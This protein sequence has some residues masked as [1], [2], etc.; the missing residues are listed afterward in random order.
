MT[1]EN[2][3][4]AD[5]N[6]P[7]LPYT[8][9]VGVST[10][11]EVCYK[12]FV[13]Y[14][15]ETGGSPDPHLI[16]SPGTAAQVTPPNHPPQIQII[17]IAQTSGSENVAVQYQVLDQDSDNVNV[18]FTLNSPCGPTVIGNS[19]TI[20]A[21]PS[22]SAT[23]IFNWNSAGTIC[24]NVE[25]NSANISAQV[26]DTPAGDFNIDNKSFLLDTKAPVLPVTPSNF[27]LVL[28]SKTNNSIT[29]QLGANSPTDS[30]PNGSDYVYKMYYATGPTVS[31]MTGTLISIPPDTPFNNYSTA[32]SKTFTVSGLTSGQQYTFNIWMYDNYG[33]KTSAPLALQETTKGLPPNNFQ[34]NSQGMRVHLSWS[35]PATPPS[36]YLIIRKKGGV[37]STWTP[38]DG[39]HYNVNDIISVDEKVVF[40]GAGNT[41]ND[42]LV[43]DVAY[44]YT[45]FSNYTTDQYSSGVS[46]TANPNPPDISS[47]TPSY[48]PDGSNYDIE[49]TWTA[50]NPSYSLQKYVV[51]AEVGDSCSID[52]APTKNVDVT[53]TGAI[54]G[55]PNEY[56]AY[57]NGSNDFIDP[58]D[59]ASGTKV[60]YKLFV[61][62]QGEDI[63][64]IVYSPGIPLTLVP[65][66]VPPVINTNVSASQA[67]GGDDVTIN[68]EVKDPDSTQLDITFSIINPNNPSCNLNLSDHLTGING[69]FSP[70]SIVWTAASGNGT[71]GDCPGFELNDAVIQVTAS[72][73]LNSVS[74]NSSGFKLDTR[75]PQLPTPSS[76][77]NLTNF[78]TSGSSISFN[79]GAQSATDVNPKPGANSVYKIYYSEGPSTDETSGA[80]LGGDG[81]NNYDTQM[82]YTANGLNPG[83]Q[84]TFNIWMYD[85][86]GHKTNAGAVEY[87]PGVEPAS[88]FTAI[89]AGMRIILNWNPPVSSTPDEYIILRRSGSAPTTN[90]LPDGSDSY[91]LNDLVNGDL[92]V[93]NGD[94]VGGNAPPINDDNVDNTTYYY[95]I[96]AYYSG[97]GKYSSPLSANATAVAED[98]TGYNA[99]SDNTKVTLFS[100][101]PND[102]TN[103]QEYLTWKIANSDRSGTW[104]PTNGVAYTENQSIGSGDII[105]LQNT[106]PNNYDD[107]PTSPSTQYCYKT[108]VEY[109]GESSDIIYSS[110][111]QLT[112][113]PTN[114]PPQVQITSVVQT[115]GSEDAMITYEVKDLD[116]DPVNVTFQMNGP[117]SGTTIDNG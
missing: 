61:Q 56:W 109:S 81:F 2:I 111:N 77:F 9:S 88:S 83:S 53:S 46:A 34:A 7:T 112:V 82:T 57:V 25:T 69:T 3:I 100:S 107:M 75:A 37:A 74:Q 89:S 48:V 15:G 94:G 105:R 90:S 97:S 68:Y 101:P 60:C 30:N 98:V 4:Y 102:T 26:T 22:W 5:A 12:T 71:T 8:D 6:P 65:P 78:S 58:V 24:P 20:A 33:H 108:F 50:P 85:A 55:Y 106:P 84:Y 99:T 31:D 1:D 87:T 76:D 17:N 18:A 117:C 79:L 115:P 96:F 43:D 41:A 23:K 35:D 39:V 10:G 64:N 73:S 80:L 52:W 14:S 92:V 36:E 91:N 42:D 72:D 44:T 16:Y 47:L 40:S 103:L 86:F 19:G 63:S 49:L 59:V 113:T 29:L 54:P 95:K 66:N 27:N 110:G 11:Q 116:S 70:H 62:Y 45:T 93:Y 13:Q 104:T 51:V 28:V 67:Y 38:T 114:N 21:T 32:Q